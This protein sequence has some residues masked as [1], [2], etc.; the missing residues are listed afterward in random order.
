M[1]ETSVLP[2]KKMK[3]V[4]C[5]ALLALVIG[6]ATAAFN[7]QSNYQNSIC[8]GSPYQVINTLATCTPSNATCSTIS[9]ASSTSQACVET[10]VTP[11]GNYLR[12]VVYTDD[13]TCSD[14]TKITGYT[15]G[16]L[17]TCIVVGTNSKVTYNGT[18]YTNNLC[19]DNTCSSCQ[20]GDSQA[21]GRCIRNGDSNTYSKPLSPVAPSTSKPAGSAS[22]SMVAV[23]AVL[24]AFLL[25]F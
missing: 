6:F 19:S 15:F 17:D 1:F 10:A 7:V 11:S 20:V 16:A 18:H 25:V 9:P 21:V 5:F 12:A 13:A 3:S 4:V 2:P 8:S 22:S 14:S 23:A 24:A